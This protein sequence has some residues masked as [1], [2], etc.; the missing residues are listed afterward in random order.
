MGHRERDVTARPITKPLR[1][2]L[3]GQRWALTL[4]PCRRRYR[5]CSG[6]PRTP[7]LPITTILF[8]PPRTPLVTGPI[9]PARLDP[10]PSLRRLSTRSAAITALRT[11]RREPPFTILQQTATLLTLRP[12][13]IGREIDEMK[14]DPREFVSLTVKSRSQASTWLRGALRRATPVPSTIL[15]TLLRDSPTAPRPGPHRDFGPM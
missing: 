13:V 11:T 8:T 4:A 6:R 10:T 7:A 9:T 12:L 14:L 15:P 1:K 5:R 3:V 2:I